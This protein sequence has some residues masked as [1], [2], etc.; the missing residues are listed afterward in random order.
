MKYVVGIDLGT[1]GVKVLLTDE[2]GTPQ[3]SARAEYLPDFYE[4]G[5]VEQD[6]EVWWEGTLK[7]LKA[8]FKENP[9]TADKVGAIAVSGQMHSSVFLDKAGK[10]IRPALLWNDTRTSK[11]VKEIFDLAGGKEKLLDMTCN[12]ALEG[13]TLPKIL[14]LKE[15]EPENFARLDRVIMPKDYINYRLSGEIATDLSDAAGTLLLDVK[16]S[17]WS[18]ELCEKVGVSPSILPKLLPSVGVVGNVKADVCSETGLKP[19]CKVVCGG[20][21]NSCAAVGNGVVKAGQGVVS[22]GT[23][24]TVI[25]FVDKIESEVTGGV[26]LFN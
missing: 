2:K 18:T 4:G 1:S 7:A 21:D 23:S 22:I 10:V 24:G 11:Q 8:L 3:A 5:C 12:L 26:H 20:A 15:N 19:E 9:D 25:G 14:W 6:P 13:F 17:D 16:K